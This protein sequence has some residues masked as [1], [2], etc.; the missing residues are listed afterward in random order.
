MNDFQAEMR[1]CFTSM[2]NTVSSFKGRMAVSIIDAE[3]AF[4]NQSDALAAKIKADLA[5]F[6]LSD[7][8][9][10]WKLNENKRKME[11]IT[12][13]TLSNNGSLQVAIDRLHAV[14]AVSLQVERTQMQLEATLQG[15]NNT[16]E[17]LVEKDSKQEGMVIDLNNL[18]TETKEKIELLNSSVISLL[19]QVSRSGQRLADYVTKQLNTTTSQNAS[20]TELSESLVRELKKVKQRLTSI[21]HQHVTHTINLKSIEN[22][23][24]S[25]ING[26]DTEDKRIK[27]RTEESS[28]LLNELQVKLDVHDDDILSR[29]SQQRE[30]LTSELQS[31]A[32]LSRAKRD[33]LRSEINFLSSRLDNCSCRADSKPVLLRCDDFPCHPGVQCIDLTHVSNGVNYQCGFCPYGTYGNGETCNRLEVGARC[34]ASGHSHYVTFD[35]SSHNFQGTCEYVLARDCYGD[36]FRV[37]IK[38]E[39]KQ[40]EDFT[41]PIAVAVSIPRRNVVIQLLDNKTIT[42]NGNAATS[43]PYALNGIKITRVHEMVMVEVNDL[44]VVIMWIPKQFVEVNVPAEYENR[45]CGLCGQYNGNA[46]DDLEAADG[47]ISQ[48]SLELMPSRSLKSRHAYHSFGRSWAVEGC[49]RLIIPQDEPCRDNTAVPIDSCA[50]NEGV[51]IKAKEYCFVIIDNSGPY[52]NCHNLVDPRVAYEDCIHDVCDCDG[53]LDCACAVIL[54]YEVQCEQVNATGLETVLDECGVCFGDGKTCRLEGATCQVYGES[55]YI[56][57]DGVGHHFQGRCEYVLAKDCLWSDFDIHVQSQYHQGN[58]SVPSILAVAIKIPFVGVI[59]LYAGRMPILNSTVIESYPYKV[60]KDGSI[61]TRSFGMTKV[62]L[63]SSGVVVTFDG[64]HFVEVYVP[65]RYKRRMCGLCGDYNGIW[66][67][68]LIVDF[69]SREYLVSSDRYYSTSQRSLQAYHNFGKAWAAKGC[70]RFLLSDKAICEDSDDPSVSLCSQNDTVLPP[71]AFKYC[72]V[73][74]SKR[75]PYA[76]CQEIVSPSLYYNSCLFDSCTCNQ[77]SELPKC[78]CQV[79]KAYEA[80]CRRHRVVDIGSVVDRCGQCFSDSQECNFMDGVCQVYGDPHY[81]TFDGSSHHFQGNCEYVL[82]KDC[83]NN[84]FQVNVRNEHRKNPSVS[85]THSVA[86]RIPGVSI[87]K[88]LPKLETRVDNSNIF[89][90]PY[91]VPGDGSVIEK[92]WGRVRVTLAASGATITWDGDH[93]VEVF[94]PSRY[95]G[96]TCGLCGTLD[97]D[98]SNDLELQTGNVVAASNF[99]YSSSQNSV[100]AYHKFGTSWAVDSHGSLLFSSNVTCKEDPPR[101]DPCQANPIV[102]V[103][104]ESYCKVIADRQGPFINCHSVV[105]PLSYYYSCVYDTCGC[106]GSRNC[107]CKV[108]IAYEAMCLRR[109]AR[110]LGS[111]ID[112]CGV[113]FGNGSSCSTNT[114]LCVAYGDSHYQTFDGISYDFQGRCEHVLVKDSHSTLFITAQNIGKLG[115]YTKTLGINIPGIAR[116]RLEHSLEVWINEIKI[117]VFPYY[118]VEDGTTLR[119]VSGGIHVWLGSSGVQVI[120]NGKDTIQIFVSTISMGM[121]TGLC[122]KYDGIHDGEFT[123]PDAVVYSLYQDFGRSWSVQGSDRLLVYSDANCSDPTELFP[124]PCSLNQ[125][126]AYEAERYCKY[127]IDPQGPYG[128][129]HATIVASHFYQ[130]CL[131]DA[132]YCMGDANCACKSVMAYETLCKHAGVRGVGTVVSECGTCF[133]SGKPCGWDDGSSG[134][135]TCLS[136]GDSHYRTFDGL[137]H[138]FQGVCEYILAKDCVGNDFVIHQRKQACDSRT[139]THSIAVRNSIGNIINLWQGRLVSVNGE[140][141]VLPYLLND[142]TEILVEGTLLLVKISGANGSTIAI[143]WDGSHFVEVV[144]PEEYARRTCGLCGTFNG[145]TSDD[146]QLPNGT[147]ASSSH[148]FGLGWAVNPLQRLLFPIASSSCQDN[149]TEYLSPCS[150]LPVIEAKAK[151][152]CSVI[153]DSQGPY[154]ACHAV[155]DPTSYYDSCLHDVC[156]CNA[157]ISCACDLVKAFEHVCRR[158]GFADEIG[159]VID[160]CGRCFGNGED[161]V[162]SGTTAQVTGDPHYRTFDGLFHH[163]QGQCEYVLVKSYNS[164]FVV[165]VLNEHRGKV[166]A[167]WTRAVAVRIECGPV[168]K[169]LPGLSM[170]VNG[171]L[172]RR[173]PYSDPTGQAVLRRIGSKIVLHLVNL[174]VVVSFD[175]IHL[176]EVT[177]SDSYRN[178]LAGLFGNFNGDSTDDLTAENGTVWTANSSQHFGSFESRRAYNEFGKSWAV[179]P[180]H[181]LLLNRN[182]S[183]TDPLPPPPFPCDMKPE[184]ERKASKYCSFMSSRHGPYTACFPVLSPDIYFQSCV[185]DICACGGKTECGCAAVSGYEQACKTLGIHNVGTVLDECGKCFGDGSECAKEETATCQVSGDPHFLTFDQSGHHFQ[186]RCEYV[187]AEDCVD[188][189]WQI[190]LHSSPCNGPYTCSKSVGIR[191]PRAGVIKLFRDLRVNVNNLPVTEFSYVIPGDG[192]TIVKRSGKLEVFLASSRVKVVWDGS[193]GVDVTIPLNERNKTCG[194]CGS[195]NGNWMDDLK[196]RN[197]SIVWASSRYSSTSATSISAYHIFGSSWAAVGDDRLLLSPND[198]CLDLS[199]GPVD[200]CNEDEVLRQR[201]TDYCKVIS[202]PHGP[203][204]KC[205]SSVHPDAHFE[206]CIYDACACQASSPLTCAC[207]SIRAYESLCEIRGVRGFGSVVDKCGVCFG[208]GSNCS[209]IGATCHA[210]GDPHYRTFDNL[211]HHFQGRCEYVL[212]K[213]CRASRWQVQVENV[214]QA[215]QS[216]SWTKGVAIRVAKVGVIRLLRNY[217][218]KVNSIR[219][220]HFPYTSPGRGVFISKEIDGVKVRLAAFDVLVSWDGSHFV[221]VTVPPTANGTVCGLC[222]QYN[223]DVNDDLQLSNGTIL[224]SSDIRGS[225]SWQSR[226]SYHEFGVS[227]AVAVPDRLLLNRS[228]ACVDDIVPPYSPCDDK[229]DIRHLAE[230]YCSFITSDAGPY[231]MCHGVVDPLSDYNSCLFDTCAC[232]GDTKCACDSVR[233]YERVCHRNK[234]PGLGSVVDECRICFGDGSTCIPDGAT[235]WATGDP[236]YITFDGLAYDFQGFCEYVFAKDLYGDF[237]IRVQNNVRFNNPTVTWTKAVALKIP[238]GASVRLLQNQV[239]E[240]NGLPITLPFVDPTFTCRVYRK[241]RLVNVRLSGPNVMITW[242]GY[243]DVSVTV[244]SRY[245]NRT[246]G[247]CSSYN[248]NQADDLLDSDGVHRANNY[249]GWQ[250]FG[251]SWAVEGRQRCLLPS[252]FNCTDPDSPFDHP[253]DGSPSLRLKA[254]KYCKFITDVKGPYVL[255]HDAI[256]PSSYYEFCLFDTCANGGNTT[257]TCDVVRAYEHTCRNQGQVQTIGTVVDEC[258][259]CFGDGSI[260]ENFGATCQAAGDSHYVTFDGAVHH[261]Q[262]QFNLTNLMCNIILTLNVYLGRMRICFSEGLQI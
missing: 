122:G 9:I 194:L 110:H 71:E 154:L 100:I 146:F 37:H 30:L 204:A 174:E 58:S 208:D 46:S 77:S 249:G 147:I 52:K 258:G 65:T 186:G 50:E 20:V 28:R 216:V 4:G 87:I 64:Q 141:V 171:K 148:E 245:F 67:D 56:T 8:K 252:D 18:L 185:F 70:D 131:R 181:R 164:K 136:A 2:N 21:Q 116:I 96:R 190:N 242:D 61:I 207:D 221:S 159:S 13:L 103:A 195:F 215:D 202:N 81:F 42:L 260:C 108:I 34:Y 235:C 22:Y 153:S 3:R 82:V 175:G 47:L 144:M 206:A 16:L 223:F 189:R 176:V 168:V 105:D 85:W 180:Q 203:Y 35:S 161:C 32:N 255:C 224:S 227:W 48:S 145:M 68:D 225:Y 80:A 118:M 214:N 243:S 40:S 256:N 143:R 89:Q 234:I 213:D 173:L 113:C 33:S 51:Q 59:R 123:G 229:P 151:R 232:N 53:D 44:G 218:V 170:V 244:P 62:R 126:T 166:N 112:K 152:Y 69:I 251:K 205:H 182:V 262:V 45:M 41:L 248:G 1:S 60:L 179:L 261:F 63:A 128:L 115:M 124:S 241:N 38:S 117:T 101:S 197:G 156:K 163:F 137:W 193:Y 158:Q 23:L 119:F 231:R 188:N 178:V 104:A 109:G 93:L 238:G 169:L 192:S 240:V 73:I 250:L 138:Y 239:V 217:V 237:D 183:C 209:K 78:A 106:N 83:M 212:A 10:E 36:D 135:A 228:S 184:I 226:N 111:V 134:G 54:S 99:K 11:A 254:E 107:A 196:L 15:Y 222:G 233:S 230:K 43:L 66:Q 200:P 14:R 210:S 191:A 187:L 201:N 79:I 139:C 97:S 26:L 90:F 7:L 246:V 55:H 31:A 199:H 29:M 259:V 19:E 142:G 6:M 198:T 125:T 75:G 177:V 86:I 24:I 88:L 114:A 172:I 25:L 127:I 5:F 95:M 57:F 17:I 84:D 236:H 160:E 12:N 219:V 91:V 162:P 72:G 155:I 150:G 165:H 133:G 92:F 94:V 132:C 167:T 253:C 130:S 157:D 102:V 74:I 98:R 257:R 220:E 211:V 120:W 27:N 49:R 39:A 247:L 149:G 76:K 129:C 140:S 121:L